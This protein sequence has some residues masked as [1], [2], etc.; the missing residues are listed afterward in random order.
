MT[1]KIVV[2]VDG[3][4]NSNAALKW[5]YAE[6]RAHGAELEVVL[7]WAYPYFADPVGGVYPMAGAFADVEAQERKLLEDQAAAV[8]KAG[9]GVKL[10]TKLVCG[11]TANTLIEEAESAD[12]LVVG[13]RGRGGFASLLLGSTSTQVVQH[14]PCPV[15]VVPSKS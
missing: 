6:A 2:G 4:E 8:S 11:A 13:S 14:A 9:D 7:A 5:A 10:T 12:L 3:S 15:V 1:K